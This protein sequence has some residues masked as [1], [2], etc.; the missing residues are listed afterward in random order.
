MSSSLIVKLSNKP[1]SCTLQ[2]SK[3]SA[4]LESA[5]DRKMDEKSINEID[6]EEYARPL[7]LSPYFNLTKI[8]EGVFAALAR[9][10]EGG[11]KSNTGLIDL[12]EYTIV[13]D[14][15]LL[16]QSSADL[17]RVS[18]QILKKEIRAIISSHHHYDHT[19]GDAA[20]PPEV[21]VISTEISRAYRAEYARTEVADFK[22]KIPATLANLRKQRVTATS[23]ID[24]SNLENQIRFYQALND[25]LTEISPRLPSITFEQSM[26]IHGR[27]R[28]VKVLSYGPGHTRSDTFLYL[29][30]DGIIFAGDL[31]FHNRHPFMAECNPHAWISVIDQILMLD[32][33]I[34][35]P[36]H[37]EITD[38][39]ALQKQQ[40]YLQFILQ[41]AQEVIAM[42]GT[43]KQATDRKPLHEFAHYTGGSYADNMRYTY[44]YLVKQ[45]LM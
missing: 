12:G 18:E 9:R 33:E 27:D 19:W 35:V 30:N 28:S 45:E 1:G 10:D 29:P 22:K 23:P 43:V 7:F 17:I 40:R 21:P 39:E 32:F 2:H 8:R 11:D 14:S 41:E 31:V 44:E 38:R 4:T 3:I 5:R 42:G 6:T 24:Q 37:G 20:F 15:F 16:P 34:V 13:F 36:G 26:E 25:S